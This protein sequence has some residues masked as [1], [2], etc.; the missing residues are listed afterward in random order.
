MLEN[1]SP[2]LTAWSSFYVMAGSSAAALTGLM[3]VVI[4]LVSAHEGPKNQDGV[5]IF[6]TPT[7]MHFAAALMVSAIF[8]APW[9]ALLYPAISV[10]L[11]GLYGTVYV[12]RVM[13]RTRNLSGYRADL[14]DWTWFHLL[15]L[16]AYGAIFGG[17]IALEFDPRKALFAIAGGVVLHIFIGIRNAWDVVTFLAIGGPGSTNS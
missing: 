16:V 8:V 14:E 13:L 2:L 10:A 1:A 15:P 9:R 5:S 4:T 12:L 3:F 7:V 6:S 17:A 11:V